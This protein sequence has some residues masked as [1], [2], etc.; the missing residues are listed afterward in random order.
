MEETPCTQNL[1][2][3]VG[4]ALVL[5]ERHCSMLM[6]EEQLPKLD[7][8]IKLTKLESCEELVAHMIR[9]QGFRVS[10]ID[11]KYQLMLLY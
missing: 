1:L 6:T 5:L 10:C 9:L 11:F 2:R 7:K 3:C 8:L 4:R